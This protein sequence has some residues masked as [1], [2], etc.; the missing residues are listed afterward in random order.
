LH[1]GQIARHAQ[2][3]F[4]TGSP[5]DGGGR[6]GFGDHVGWHAGKLG[7]AVDE[8]RPIVGRIEHVVV[9]PRRQAGELFLHRLE[10]R[11]ALVRQLRATEVKI[12]QFV[13]HNFFS[14]RIQR[15]EATRRGHGPIATEQADVLAE[16]GIERG[17]LRQCVVVRVAQLRRV[18]D[19]V[20]VPH[21]APRAVD[22]VE[23]LRQRL[24]DGVPGGRSRI[25]GHALDR[26]PC[27]GEQRVD[28][29]G[30]VRGANDVEA[31]EAGKIE[32]RVRG[33]R[34]IVR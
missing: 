10:P 21:G 28:G 9:E 20:Q 33:H 19:G 24:D 5:V 17:D 31:G 30:D 14:R 3:Q 26:G 1:D 7:L 22:A 34:S 32:Q 4:E 12:A 27:V 29:R 16:I 23:C 11:L 18:D 25:R 15:R 6:A 8:Q 2:R 13:G